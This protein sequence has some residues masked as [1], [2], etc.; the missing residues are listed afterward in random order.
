MTHLRK[1]RTTSVLKWVFSNFSQ[2]Q[3]SSSKSR[4]W[5]TA[6]ALVSQNTRLYRTR[7]VV[8][9]EKSEIFDHSEADNGVRIPRA[10]K[11][12]AQ[13]ALL[14][15]FYSTRNL[16]FLDAENMSRNSPLFLGRLLKRINN[17]AEV[18]RSI[19]RFLCYHPINEFEP[20]L[21]S[22]GLKPSEY[23]PL[24][25]RDLMYLTDARLLLENYYVLCGYGFARQKIG[26]IYKEATE[27]FYS[28]VEILVSKLRSYEKLSLSQSTL[29]KLFISSPYL[30]IGN[31]NADFVEVL[32]KIRSFGF[33]TGWIEGNLVEGNA[34]N[35]SHMLGVLRLFNEMG[36]TKEQLAEM[37][38]WHP[39]ILFEDSG[40]RAILLVVFLLKFGFSMNQ[41]GSMFMQFPKT[42]VG[43]FVSNLRRCFVVLNEIE[44]EVLDI[45]DFVRSHTLLVGSSSLKRANSLLTNLCVGKKRLCSYIQENPHELKNLVLGAKVKPLPSLDQNRES[46]LQKNKFL[47]DLGY[48]EDSN[49]MKAALKVFRGK[50][51]ELQERFDIIMSYG[52]DR[53]K[54]C[55]MVNVSP[56]IL[57]QTKN[58]IQT[59]IDLLVK[60][61]GYPIS[62]L[63]VFPSYLNYT[64]ERV[65]LRVSMYDWLKAQGAAD[66]MLALSTII[67]SSESAFFKQ[68]VNRHP[69]GPQVWQDLKEKLVPTLN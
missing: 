7:R 13:A 6:Y 9:C 37:F 4:V 57:N 62:A 50:G 51:G 34:Y 66:P 10:V 53:E 18:G 26:K 63:W 44:M 35:W 46:K 43:K 65:K 22:L 55:E 69:N 5:S 25:P 58:V 40:N 17:E 3:L 29:V 42:Q 45:G 27:V 60:E 19:A 38:G 33:E 16:Q 1:L 21:E 48:V 11:K 31:V 61:L 52:L 12:E 68:Y 54:V 56:Q 64:V 49:E 47:L 59:K 39:D 14:E 20:F 23:V 32:E 36:L 67:A 41:I 15:Y 28:D 24:L 2:N 8:Q 30:L